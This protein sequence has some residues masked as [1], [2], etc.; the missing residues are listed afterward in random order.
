MENPTFKLHLLTAGV[1]A[2]TM[3]ATACICWSDIV[4]P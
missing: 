2:W 4:L 3:L 1:L